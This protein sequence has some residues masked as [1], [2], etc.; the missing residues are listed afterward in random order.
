MFD[1][2]GGVGDYYEDVDDFLKEDQ[3]IEVDIKAKGMSKRIR[4]RALSF[5]QMEK[6]NKLSTVEGKT[7]N[8]EFV[9]NTI[10]EGVVRPKFNSAQAKRLLDAHGETVKEIAENIWQL[11]RISKSTFEEYIKTVQD[12]KDVPEPE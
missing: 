8:S 2:L 6:I 7:D 4:I 9:I 10:I 3:T 12:L 1:F 11:G 5:A